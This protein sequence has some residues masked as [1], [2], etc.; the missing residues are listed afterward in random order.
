MQ[1]HPRVVM[2]SCH[3]QL[4]ARGH[5][6]TVAVRKHAQNKT[7]TLQHVQAW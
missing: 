5:A 6:T 1:A 3:D 2:E 7:P 4:Q